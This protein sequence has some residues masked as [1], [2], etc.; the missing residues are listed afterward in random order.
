VWYRCNGQITERGPYEGRC[1]GKSIKGDWIEPLVW[2]DLERWLRDPGEIIEELSLQADQAEQQAVRE[3]ERITLAT[4]LQDLAL[5]RQRAID[6][7]VRGR[8]SD[9][10]LDQQLDQI[11]T[12][13]RKVDARLMEI[14][15]LEEATSEPP[16]PMDLLEEV[17]RR[18]DEGFDYETRREITRLLVRQ[19][20]VHTELDAQG[21]K[22]A[23]L[24]VE[25]RFPGVVP[26][27]TDI[28]ASQN[29]HVMQRLVCV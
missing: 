1:P 3:A 12:E 8:I 6:L 16:L 4:Q 28:R 18:L 10:E 29:Y 11:D 14:S 20:T 22:T 15:D 24:I 21:K 13:R 23:R 2:N 25:Y 27:H 17:R 26:D 9:A 5:R 19:V 7:S